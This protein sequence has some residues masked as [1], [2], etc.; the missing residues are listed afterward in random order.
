MKDSGRYSNEP[1]RIW[2][3]GNNPYR[4]LIFW[5]WNDK[6]EPSFLILYGIHKFLEEK[7][8][9]IDNSYI[10][11]FEN[12]LCDEVTYS[13]YVIFNGMEGHLPSFEAVNIVEDGGYRYRDKQDEFPKMYYKKDSKYYGWSRNLIE[14]G[15]VKEYVKFKDGHGV[16]I[17]YFEEFSYEELVQKVKDAN[18]TFK[19]FKFAKSPNEILELPEELKDYYELLCIMM[20]DKNL[21]TRKKKLKELIESQPDNAIYKYIFKLG[22]TELISGLFLECAK[23]EIPL[24]ISEAEYICKADIHYSDDSYVKGLKRCADI[25]LNT[26]IK[27]RRLE[28]EKWIYNNLSEIDLNLI[29][30]DGKEISEGKVLEGTKYRMLCHQEK[31]KEYY[32]RYEQTSDGKWKWTKTRSEDRYKKGPFNDGV[33]FDIKAF[34]NVLQEAE[35][36]KMADVIAKIAYYIDAPRLHYYFKG[37]GLSKELNYFKRYIRRIIEDY[38]KNDSDKFMEVMKTLLTSYTKNDFL[39]KFKGN[40]QFNYFIKYLL[41][42][43]F[44][45]KPPVSDYYNWEERYNWMKNDQLLSLQGR[46]EFMKEIWDNHLEDV[47]YIATNS[48]IDTVF[49]ACYF[50]LKDSERVNELFE[51]IT[52]E[53]LIKLT[54]ITYAPLA[55]MFIETLNNKLNREEKFD[56]KIMLALMNSEDKNIN[57]LGME[58]LRRTNGHIGSDDIV[59]L[60]LCDNLEKWTEYI[61]L[62][63][64]SIKSEDYSKFVKAMINTDILF[65]KA[66]LILPKSISEAISE[67]VNKVTE[68][69]KT[70]KYE[71][72]KDVIN[73]II[74]KGSMESFVESFLE[75]VIFAL[76]YDEIIEILQDFEFN[77]NNKLLSSRNNMILNLIDSIINNKIP[78]DSSIIRIIEAGTSKMLKALFELVNT[79]KNEL[80]KRY[81]TMLIFLES[82]VV[83][84]SEESK[85]I[86]NKMNEECRVKM[87]KIII[88]SP[89]ERVYTFGLEKLEEIYGEF[90]PADFIRQMLEHTSEYVKGYISSKTEIILNSLGEGNEDL[91][92]YYAKTLLLL[93]NKIRKNKVDVYNALYRFALKYKERQDEVEKL[94]LDMGGSNII[95]DSEKALVTL[96]KIRKETAV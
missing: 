63:I 65:K 85:E 8:Y 41:Y 11:R 68:M 79:N 21:F 59:K 37:N 33:V 80:S 88:D 95:N 82:D 30:I 12:V 54:Q 83:M 16:T 1:K 92:M 57:E 7:S 49:K 23:R 28:R 15:I 27:D 78:S 43:D 17:P 39:C 70:E 76:S 56:F 77:Y 84:L 50:I 55:E 71:I 58:Y 44:K 35:A 53:E 48:N 5:G 93:P 29:K 24:F 90:V 94:L 89:V 45:E 64:N 36:Y 96:A 51:K 67:S 25:Y 19:N 10:E 22:S 31:L 34:K 66:S 61:I 60:F 26:V 18:L 13:S 14:D 20:S 38:A 9:Y 86:F 62:N 6:N 74:E 91:F 46:Y 4:S 52:Y 42:Y 3:Q 40:F 75:E 47:I 32:G 73:S 69:M 81:S 2:K 87:H 72:I